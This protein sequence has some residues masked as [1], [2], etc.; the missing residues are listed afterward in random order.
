MVRKII[1]ITAITL[2]FSNVILSQITPATII[3]YRRLQM[4]FDLENSSIAKEVV[5]YEGTPYLLDQFTMADI[6]L[7]AGEGYKG[8]P[9]NYNIYNDD[10]EFLMDSVSYALGNN[11]IINHININGRKFYYLTYTYNAAE[12]KGYLELVAD[13]KYRF[14]KKHRVIYTKPQPPSGYVE[15]QAAKFSSRSPDYFIELIDGNIV[16]F[17][18][19]K[20]I[21]EMVPEQGRNINDYI[22]DKK[23]KARR[24]EDIIELADFINGK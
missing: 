11:S 18:N 17:N 2:S 10:F 22:K 3:D 24:E 16:Y 21:A 7:K 19:L 1:L 8:I 15:A 23:L 13:G 12:I 4:D 20:D 5:D 14:F 6:L 9:M